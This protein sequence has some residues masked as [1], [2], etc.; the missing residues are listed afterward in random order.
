MLQ[1]QVSSFLFHSYHWDLHWSI[2]KKAL[3]EPQVDK[4]LNKILIN[5]DSKTVLASA[6]TKLDQ[7]IRA[8]T[9]TEFSP[10]EANKTKWNVTKKI[11]Y[12]DA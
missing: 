3:K 5:V 1:Y 12:S 10:S 9:E 4:N 6:V 8:V 11:D 2:D 7:G